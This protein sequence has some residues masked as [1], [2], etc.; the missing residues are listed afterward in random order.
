MIDLA[1]RWEE[2]LNEHAL[3]CSRSHPTSPPTA[4]DV[5]RIREILLAVEYRD[6]AIVVDA[7]ERGVSLQVVTIVPDSFT[8][9]PVA[10]NGRPIQV[11]PAIS[12]P[13]L[14]DLAFE[15][16]R[17]FELHE[18]AERFRLR[19]QRLYF[20]HHSTGKPYFRVPSARARAQFAAA[21]PKSTS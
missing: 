13:E 5:E 12:E 15:L 7:G 14:A 20:P 6:W 3:T 11:C 16:L 21:E 8:G 4:E 9:E 1:G 17:E 10:N 2:I 19:G 18:S